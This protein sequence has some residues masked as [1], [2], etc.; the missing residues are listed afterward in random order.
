MHNLA[1]VIVNSNAYNHVAPGLKVSY[2][3]SPWR[4]ALDRALIGLGVVGLLCLVWV[5]LRQLD[6]KK[7]PNKYQH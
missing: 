2:T 5:V 3:T 1:Y 6:D 7:H 4:I